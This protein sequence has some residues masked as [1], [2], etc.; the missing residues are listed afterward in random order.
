MPGPL[1]RGVVPGSV[2]GGV[3]MAAVRAAH[4]VA[5]EVV[6]RKLNAA[7]M[8]PAAEALDTAA[9]PGEKPRF[10]RDFLERIGAKT[11]VG[12]SKF[13]SL[14]QHPPPP[15]SRIHLHQTFK[16]RRAVLCG[17]MPKARFDRGMEP[18]E[19]SRKLQLGWLTGF[20]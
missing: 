14:N 19:E 3:D 20:L 6:A 17:Q 7:D 2:H 4:A 16:Y 8:A 11:L 10:F 15:H 13:N 9:A 5:K 12:F 1:P 18:T